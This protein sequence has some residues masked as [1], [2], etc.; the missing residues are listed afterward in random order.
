MNKQSVGGILMMGVG[1]AGHI[2]TQHPY[3]PY[4]IAGGACIT[5]AELFLLHEN[6]YERLFRKCGIKNCDDKIP[7]VIKQDKNTLVVHMP[8]GISQ[9]QFE[10]KQLEIEQALN[11]KIEFGFNK[12][13]I[14][15]LTEA[16]LKPFYKY[17]FEPCEKPLE[18]F[19]G[20]SHGGKFVLDI[21]KC[22]HTI[23][24]GETNS[25]KSSLLRNMILSLLLS[26]HNVE[27]H[28][29]D[30]QAVELGIYENCRKVKSYGE[31]PA[32]FDR[33]MDEMAEEN[34]RRL[35][36]FRSV[37][38][39][40]F[41]QNLEAWNKHYPDKT[42]PHKVVIVDEFSRLSD[43]EYEDILSK[44]RTR[45]SMD[46]KT[47]IHYIIAMQRPDVTCIQGSI[48]ANMPCRI[49]FR[50]V[51]QVDSEVIL[52]LPG[53]EKIKQQGRCLVKYGGEVKEMQSLYIDNEQV[54][55]VLRR[56]RCFKTTAELQQERRE[57]IAKLRQKCINPYIKGVV[58]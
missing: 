10:Q 53:A 22:P 9:K 44:F 13:L 25:G 11:A 31:T 38:G 45:V 17:T 16:N 43:K 30:F 35:K 3:T 14:I 46:R 7:L 49:A 24:A 57:H 23:I 1:V 51:T 21:E 19:C 6:K 27:L 32:D 36:L 42:L 18:V 2:I 29:I 50:T 52:D 4:L 58:K 12:N 56:N 26:P 34:E 40:R 47:G 8:E 39:K 20:Y 33:L 15:K 5:A 37:K 28:L 55:G 41:I 54:R 48:K